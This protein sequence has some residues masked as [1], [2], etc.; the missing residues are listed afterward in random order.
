MTRNIPDQEHAGRF[1]TFLEKKPSLYQLCT[2]PLHLTMFVES[3]KDETVFPSSL[4]EAYTKSISKSF[5]REIRR[6][7]PVGCSNVRLTDL[8]SLRVYNSDLAG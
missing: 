4:M 5:K 8:S 3:V 2:I 6:K 7:N 1:L